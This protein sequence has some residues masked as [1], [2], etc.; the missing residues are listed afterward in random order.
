M[1]NL[2]LYGPK[3]EIEQIRKI[4]EKYKNE[5]DIRN[6]RILYRNSP[7]FRGE[8]YGYDA[9]IKETI[10]K[11]SEIPNLLETIDKMPMGSIEKRIRES[12]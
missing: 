12:S 6:V 11:P 3:N 4:V 2:I 8:L 1:R 9:G 7:N 5:F 10:Y